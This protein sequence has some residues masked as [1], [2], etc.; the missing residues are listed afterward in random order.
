M[1]SFQFPANPSDGDI[2][3]RGNLQA[4]Y[5]AA[6]NTW[7]VSEV[8]TAPGIPG[9]P[10]PPGPIGPPG[11]GVE[12]SGVV[13]TLA[14]LPAENAHQ[15]E[16]WVV[17]DTN[18]LY[19]SDGIQ[20]VALGGPIQGPQG[21]PGEDGQDGTNGQNGRGWYDTNIIDERPTNYQVQFLSNDGLGFTT[22]NIMG[23]QGET[24]SL[25]V[26]TETTL[27]GIK[28]GR[29]L[30]IL[31]DGT[32]QAGQT[33]VNLET[34]PVAPEQGIINLMSPY[35]AQYFTMG[36]Y[37]T[38]SWVG[39]RNN[40]DYSTDT[41]TVK[42]P[43]KANKALIFLFA[44]STMKGSPNT[45]FDSGNTRSFRLYSSHVMGLTNA[46]YTSG[47]TTSLG[48]ANNHNICYVI[49]SAS[50][51]ARF[52][53]TPTT[54]INQIEFEQGGTEVTF[55]Y[56]YRIHKS[57][58]NEL[59][60][61]GIQV[62]L[63]PFRD[64]DDTTTAIEPAP[65]GTLIR[66]SDDFYFTGDLE[67]IEDIVYPPDTEESLNTQYG[68]AF[69]EEIQHAVERINAELIYVDGT[70]AGDQLIAYRDQLR[71]TR[72]LPGTAEDIN[73]YLA[74]ILNAVNILLD[75]KFRFE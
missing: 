66:E 6:T 30:D 23:P 71:D 20:W 56:T 36:E 52:S 14:D 31:P 1:S 10:G 13:D 63:I 3:V 51:A 69:R 53:T 68:D 25:Q 61:G 7:R 41:V 37:K 47:N 75:Y 55:D 11:K 33:S 40:Y 67:D 54:K 19:I 62:I 58:S 18:T 4:F 28:I 32:A 74:P 5:N 39:A 50:L 44:S 26:A 73:N 65:A 12:V 38:E 49:N 64:V 70:P 45:V 48:M 17:S 43:E 27:G 34:T 35:Q 16:Y 57:G 60:G 2:V 72:D 29:G 59:T 9:P 15:F 42:M 8:P 21:E 46:V 24:G 22:D